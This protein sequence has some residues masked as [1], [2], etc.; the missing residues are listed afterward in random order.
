M[1]QKET[2]I[3]SFKKYELQAK[4]FLSLNE[5]LKVDVK[6]YRNQID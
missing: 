5:S 2:E 3:I 6:Y 1:E 4:K